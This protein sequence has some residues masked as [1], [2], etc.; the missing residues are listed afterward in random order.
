MAVAAAVMLAVAWGGFFYQDD[1]LF[2]RQGHDA[3]FGLAYLREGA[4]GHFFP[5]FR[6]IFWAQDRTFGLNHDVAALLVAAAHVACLGMMYRLLTLLFGPRPATLGLLGAFSFSGLWLSGYLWWVSAI[7]VLPAMFLTIAAID[8][9]V[10]Y[11]LE[12]RGVH[13]V[14]AAAALAVA[15][16]FYEKPVQLLLMLPLL[17]GL[18]LSAAT[19]PAAIARELAG[20]W[21]MWAAFALVLVVYA[22][23]YLTGDFFVETV[24][25]SA[26]TFIRTV[27]VGWHQGFVPSFLGGPVDLEKHGSLGQPDP[28]RLLTVTDQ[29][30]LIALV[31]ASLVRRRSAWRGWFYLVV[32]FLVNITV[33]AWTRS[34]LLGESV[35]RELKYL[36]DILPF[37][38]LGVGLALVP[39]H[40]GPRAESLPAPAADSGGARVTALRRGAAALVAVVFLAAFGASAAHVAGFWHDGESAD[41]GRGIAVSRGQI[42]ELMRS[43]AVFADGNVSEGVLAAVFQPY[44]R[45][46]VLLPLFGLHLRY[47]GQGRELVIVE[48]GGTVHPRTVQPAVTLDV[49][50][51]QIDGQPLA[52]QAGAACMRDDDADHLLTLPLSAPLPPGR[53]YLRLVTRSPR[54]VAL[55]FRQEAAIGDRVNHTTQPA[56]PLRIDGTARPLYLPLEAPGAAA[57]EILVMRHNPVCVESGVAGPVRP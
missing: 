7:Q 44:Q 15:L 43:G 20:L 47:A 1:F 24:H 45:H 42:D 26:H 14:Q 37:A 55:Q 23:A 48:K 36:I 18:A 25:P 4:F 50:G 40:V 56:D 30:L 22:V 8:G 2:L 3:S 33:I 54:P 53:P 28:S 12:R 32:A 10:R 21:R 19:T 52:P 29:L 13:I 34:G 57:I 46:S 31:A 5:G 17:T 35:G 38:V 11:V 51:A 39:L 6:A 9:H 27:T 49:A 16:C 41:L